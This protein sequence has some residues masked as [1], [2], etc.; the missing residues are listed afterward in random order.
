MPRMILLLALFST[1]SCSGQILIHPDPRAI[2]YIM[3][4][5]QPP[6]SVIAP[7]TN[8]EKEK[9][10]QVYNAVLK[11]DSSLDEEGD[12]VSSQVNDY[13]NT[14]MAAMVKADPEV[15]P[16]L[17]ASSGPITSAQSDEIK[18]AQSAAMQADPNLQSQWD[19][20]MKKMTA[21]QQAVDAAMVKLDPTVADIWVKLSP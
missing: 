16:I 1:L 20:L 7:M 17:Q 10:Q 18:K 6:R 2:S 3:Y 13:R 15:T 5:G 8:E 11:G 4:A 14:L 9:L 12:A 21:H 19:D